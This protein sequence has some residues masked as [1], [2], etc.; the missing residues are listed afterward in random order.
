[1]VKGLTGGGGSRALRAWH[2]YREHIDRRH[3]DEGRYCADE[4]M[5]LDAQ[6]AREEG[7][8]AEQRRHTVSLPLS[9]SKAPPPPTPL[10]PLLALL[11]ALPL[12]T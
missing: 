4:Q 7:A 6:P 11:A 10:A 3:P 2:D 12:A 9:I 1:M 8:A 5:P